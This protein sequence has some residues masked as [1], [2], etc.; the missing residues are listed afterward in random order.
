MF[1]PQWEKLAH[2]V[3]DQCSHGVQRCE[4]R[5]STFER[6]NAGQLALHL[7]LCLRGVGPDA[8]E[9]CAVLDRFPWKEAGLES[10]GLAAKHDHGSLVEALVVHEDGQDGP[11]LVFVRQAG[12]KG[13]GPKVLPSR[14]RLIPLHDCQARPCDTGQSTVMVGP[15]PPSPSCG[16][17]DGV[18]REIDGSGFFGWGLSPFKTNCQARWSRADR[19][20]LR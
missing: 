6:Y 5:V 10:D 8:K 4:Q 14:V 11:V 20:L 12:K 18:E 7:R 1:S 9:F 16:S 17:S 19:R 13:Q 2:D 15:E 3:A